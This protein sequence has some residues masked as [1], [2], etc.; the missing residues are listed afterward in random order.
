MQN[1]QTALHTDLLEATAA[2]TALLRTVVNALVKNSEAV[3]ID[4]TTEDDVVHITVSVAQDD[5]NRV[6]GFQGRTIRSIRT[7]L[8]AISA[9]LHRR[10]ELVVQQNNTSPRTARPRT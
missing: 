8:Q 3:T 6:I 5:L 1:A 4:S 2:T 9:K 10:F 7:V